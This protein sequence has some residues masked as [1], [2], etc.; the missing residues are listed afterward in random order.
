MYIFRP[1]CWAYT[2]IILTIVPTFMEG[3]IIIVMEKDP[4]KTRSTCVST[5]CEYTLS[6]QELTIWSEG[7]HLVGRKD[8]Q[9][10]E[11]SIAIGGVLSVH[12]IR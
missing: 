11:N 4:H 6:A 8:P 10:G 1:Y 7:L 9:T 3:P 2:L 12:H 5:P